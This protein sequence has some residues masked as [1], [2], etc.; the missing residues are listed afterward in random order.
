MKHYL[1]SAEAVFQA[2]E[3]SPEGLTTQQAELRL[4]QNGKN[5]LA[6]PKRTPFSSGLLTKCGTL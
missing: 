1:E 3:S 2:V 5:K 4:E 6:E